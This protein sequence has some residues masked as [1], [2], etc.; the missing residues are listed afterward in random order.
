MRSLNKINEY[1]NTVC[2]NIRWKKARFRISEEITN[3]LI[4]GRDSYIEQGLDEDSATDKSIS[5]TGNAAIVGTQLDRVHRPKP[6]WSMFAWIAGFLLFGILVSVLVFESI[7]ISGR[8][9]P[10][11]GRYRALLRVLKQYDKPMEK[12]WEVDMVLREGKAFIPFPMINIE[13]LES[14]ERIKIEFFP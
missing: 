5:D 12:T 3:H 11:P 4:D 14:W 9:A 8:L 2:Q 6:Q 13:H 10:P 7:D 1:V